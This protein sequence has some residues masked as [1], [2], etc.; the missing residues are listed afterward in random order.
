MNEK[1]LYVDDIYSKEN[2]AR[3][4]ERNFVAANSKCVLQLHDS[5]DDWFPRP[6]TEAVQYTGGTVEARQNQRLDLTLVD[7]HKRELF[8][9]VT[10]IVLQRL[11]PPRDK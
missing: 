2:T 7:R 8:N 10:R 1:A 4:S 6:L 9:T 11:Y 3:W 5:S